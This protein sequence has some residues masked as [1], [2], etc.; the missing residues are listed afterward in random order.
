MNSPKE[1]FEVRIATWDK[2]VKGLFDYSA[3]VGLKRDPRFNI[4]NH[5]KVYRD[6]THG[7]NY[8]NTIAKVS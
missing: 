3:T 1:S 8:F 4:S 2:E 6:N 5:C 7:E